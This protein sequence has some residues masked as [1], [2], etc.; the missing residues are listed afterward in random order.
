MRLGQLSRKLE[1]S[2]SK[3]VAF[4]EKEFEVSLENHPNTKVD[5]AFLERIES[6]FKVEKPKHAEKTI[7]KELE[8][9]KETIPAAE[10]TEPVLEQ[11][12]AIEV[13]KK[14]QDPVIE[15]EQTATTPEAEIKTEVKTEEVEIELIKAP[16]PELK[17][18]KVLR[19]IELPTKK[20]VITEAEQKTDD[21]PTTTAKDVD[22]IEREL[23]ASLNQPA[24]IKRKESTYSRPNKPM[25]KK[26]S[27]EEILAEKQ[28]RE[29]IER[30]AE[31]KRL[32]AH[33]EREK[34]R[35]K[36]HY[37]THAEKLTTPKKKKKKK[38]VA[39]EIVSKKK[40]VQEKPKTWIGRLILWFQTS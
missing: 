32:K 34:K 12:D 22:K 27:V 10:K 11:T 15:T 3:I 29:E 6:E 31:E 33:Q 20:V 35:K 36:E 18:I 23:Q 24:P 19:T 8:S 38:T 37:K 13:E 39:E 9:T 5:D 4:I 14:S 25:Q 21:A 40:E 30:L 26:K 17:Q 28:K 16:K 7:N 1:L 2:T